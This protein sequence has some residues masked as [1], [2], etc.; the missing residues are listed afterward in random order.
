MP[1][2]S[3]QNLVDAAKQRYGDTTLRR[4]MRGAHPN[5]ESIDT[6]AAD[7]ELVEIANSVLGTIE[8]AAHDSETSWPLPSPY[9]ETWPGEL[10]Q[11]ALELF[12][13]RTKSGLPKISEHALRLGMEAEK[14]FK[15]L[16]SGEHTWNIGL[17]EDIPKM[18]PVGSRERDGTSLVAGVSDRVNVLED[19]HDFDRPFA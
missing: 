12:D 9:N 10:F 5:E 6:N 13:Y 18:E 7:A 3:A 14:Y 17:T 19:M 15:G 2:F 1:D 4:R 16:A 8:A 11:K